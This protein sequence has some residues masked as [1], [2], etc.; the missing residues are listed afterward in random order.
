MPRQNEDLLTGYDTKELSEIAVQFLTN[1]LNGDII[2]SHEDAS[3]IIK[4]HLNR[5]SVAEGAPDQ[6]DLGEANLDTDIAKLMQL[7]GLVSES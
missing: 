3:L 5:L 6:Y 7:L 1:F 2:I 4:D